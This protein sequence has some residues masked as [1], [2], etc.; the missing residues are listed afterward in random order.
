MGQWMS[1]AIVAGLAG[2]LGVGV[3]VSAD[4]ILDTADAFGLSGASDAPGRHVT[5]PRDGSAGGKAKKQRQNPNVQGNGAAL[6]GAGT[7]PGPLSEAEKERL[8]VKIAERVERRE[9]MDVEVQQAIREEKR[10]VWRAQPPEVRRAE[11]QLRKARRE[12]R[13]GLLVEQ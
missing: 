6:R 7:R 10:A 8:A 2:L 12:I 5:L 3:Y 13:E 9:T 4:A 1:R 11:R